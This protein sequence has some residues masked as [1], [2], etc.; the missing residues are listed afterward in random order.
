M[1]LW[2]TGNSK[3]G[4]TVLA[5]ELVS[6]NSIVLD[7]DDMRKIWPELKYDKKDRIKS[8]LRVARLAKLFE[9]KGLDIIV[10]TICPY[11]EL[12]KQVKKICSCI[13]V[14]VP[15]GESDSKEYPYEMP[16][17]EITI[18]SF[19]LRRKHNG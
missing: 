2:I 4:K 8:N 14:H 3:A 12:R 11:I 15:G 17:N 9:E 5:N 16:G 18:S 19:Q 7:G 10:A 1:I 13:F 6:N